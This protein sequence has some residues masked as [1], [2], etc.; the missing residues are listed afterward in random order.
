MEMLNLGCGR[1][2]HPAWINVDFAGNAPHVL[3]HDL[4]KGIPF[5]D[6]SFQVV[7]HSHLLEHFPRE[8][9]PGFL[10]ECYRVLGPGGLLR[11]VVPDLEGIAKLF[12]ERL[13]AAAAAQ[14]GADADYDW[15]MLELYDQTVRT[16]PG[17][18][19]KR[20]LQ[21]AEIPNREFIASR[22]GWLDESQQGEFG[23][24]TAGARGPSRWARI[25]RRKTWHERFKRLILG[26]EYEVL[27]EGRFRRSGEMHA[28]MYDRFSLARLLDSIGFVEI[29][30][31]A[32][33]ESAIADWALYRLDVE[34]NGA[35]RKPDSLF[36]E[37]RKPG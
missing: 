11:V 16:E 18:A 22:M 17:G 32:A 35:V 14:P 13:S 10:R 21:Q 29:R 5:A 26:A 23:V 9:A 33:A 15:L 31:C 34:S 20:Y 30:R 4:K 25:L 36:M 24:P 7:Y 8:L 2:F 6:K 27:Q 19:M 12:L 28:W 37:C 3:G 1:R